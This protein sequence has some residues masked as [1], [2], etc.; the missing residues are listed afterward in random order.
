MAEQTTPKQGR[1]NPLTNAMQT[2]IDSFLRQAMFTLPGKVS[3]FDSGTQLAQVEIGIN[4]L[5][6]DGES[7]PYA[8]IEGVPV[9]FPGDNEWFLFHQITPGETEGLIHFSQ[10]AI[11]TWLDQGGPVAPH[12]ARAWSAEDAFFAPGYRSKPGAIPTLPE[13]GAGISNYDGSV[14]IHAQ[15]DGTIL[16]DNGAAS[17]SLGGDGMVKM[18]GAQ[19]D[20][21]SA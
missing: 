11:D 9:Q 8:I 21:E 6:A 7:R 18:T 2:A 13:E 14:V 20:W 12:E 5:T 10:R 17:L 4:R 1:Q 19:F 15:A 16:L 3:T